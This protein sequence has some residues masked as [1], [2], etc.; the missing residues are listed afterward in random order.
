MES[1]RNERPI[2]CIDAEGDAGEM[3]LLGVA[4]YDGENGLYIR[5]REEIVD[6]LLYYASQGYDFVA[7]NAQ[8]D[9]VVIFWQLD[10]SAQAV[11]YNQRFNHGRWFFNKEKPAAR[12]WDTLSISAF[13]SLAKVGEA[14]G[15]SK[16]QTPCNLLSE[17]CSNPHWYCERHNIGECEDC[18]AIRDA[19]ICYAYYLQYKSLL[20][21]Y[22]V[23]PKHTLGSAAVSL[24]KKLDPNQADYIKSKEMAEF[25][26]ESFHGGRTEPFKYGHT[27][28]IY[29]ADINGMYPS[30][31]LNHPMPDTRHLEYTESENIP[32]EIFKYEGVSECLVT[33]PLAYI[34]I[35]P[36][37]LQEKLLF[38]VGTFRGVWT[39]AELRASIAAGYSIQNIF[40]S[41]ITR[42]SCTPF[43]SY[44][45]TLIELRKQYKLNNDPRELVAKILANSLYGRMGLK[46][47]QE[48]SIYVRWDG[49]KPLSEYEGWDIDI[50]HN[51]TFLTHTI[52]R[53]QVSHEANILWASYITSLA[54]I[55]LYE[56][57]ILQGTDIVYCDTD[58]IY[59]LAPIVGTG[60]GFGNL[61]E[62]ETFNRGY[63]KGP[64]LYRLESDIG[65]NKVRAR[66]VPKKYADEFLNTGYASFKQPLTVKD[67]LKRRMNAGEWVLMSRTQQ[68]T[69]S[70]RQVLNPEALF[71]PGGY[72]ETAPLFIGL[73][74][75]IFG[76]W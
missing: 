42:K 11:F 47:H 56:F 63:F 23:P 46:S 5:N 70:K 65:E 49:R 60:T 58:S 28:P 24:W 7:H 13:L 39:H 44:I 6:K 59:S 21:Q 52:E 75:D 61:I 27:G 1:R 55:R 30:I 9:L 29:T 3:G 67:A 35:L 2:V 8:Y 73:D 38:P 32:I 53:N 25:I 36:A 72:S 33:S 14:I 64:K 12:I 66:G 31:M 16:L 18:Y 43:T 62:E 19:E 69:M 48:E 50:Q 40:R 54:R 71:T 17:P 15:L 26:R 68:L 10:I 41:L 45:T 76:E 51:G 20:A 57:L 4:F 22:G 37:Y 74:G 34:P